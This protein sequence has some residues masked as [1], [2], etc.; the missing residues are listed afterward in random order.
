M[1]TPDLEADPAN[2][3]MLT[4]TLQNVHKQAAVGSSYAPMPPKLPCYRVAILL[5]QDLYA[6]EIDDATDYGFQVFAPPRTGLRPEALTAALL[7]T[8]HH[9]RVRG[10]VQAIRQAQ[11]PAE[12][13][14]LSIWARKHYLHAKNVILASGAY[15][16]RLCPS[17]AGIVKPLA[18]H[19]IDLRNAAALP[20][21]LMMHQGH[22][23]VHA[24]GANWRMVGWSG[25]EEDILPVMAAVAQQLCPDAPS[26]PAI[27]GG[28]RSPMG[29]RWW[30]KRRICRMCT[31]SMGWGR[32]VGVGFV[33]P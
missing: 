17:L 3:D 21:P 10:R 30:A 2:L 13:T 22:V 28:R 31:S 27:P 18:M 25:T 11:R 8:Q 23:V 20:S 24:H 14:M 7:A 16:A 33:S 1:R 26:S 15:A 32:V 5:R 9:R 19:A 12:T 29:C 6:T 4:A